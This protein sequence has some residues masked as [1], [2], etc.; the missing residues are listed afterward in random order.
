MTEKDVMTSYW[1][2]ERRNEEKGTHQRGEKGRCSIYFIRREKREGERKGR[3]RETGANVIS[4]SRLD[5]MLLL[6]L[7]HK[8]APS[9][10]GCRTHS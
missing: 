6:E 3:R 5:R 4:S 10:Y 1:A 9:H 7:R 2:L 8:P